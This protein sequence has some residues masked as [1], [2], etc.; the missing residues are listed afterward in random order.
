M[1]ANT[2]PSYKKVYDNVELVLDEQGNL[3]GV[4]ASDDLKNIAIFIS[5]T[6]KGLKRQA[7]AIKIAKRII[8]LVKHRMSEPTA[9]PSDMAKTIDDSIQAGLDANGFYLDKDH[10]PDLFVP[11]SQALEHAKKARD[12]ARQSTSTGFYNEAAAWAPYQL[13]LLIEILVRKYFAEQVKKAMSKRKAAQMINLTQEEKEQIKPWLQQHVTN[14][15]YSVPVNDDN[16]YLGNEDIPEED[17]QARDESHERVQAGW[18]SEANALYTKF[19]LL[20][21]SAHIVD[22]PASHSDDKRK[23]MWHIAAITTFDTDVKDMPEL[24]KHLV[25]VARSQSNKDDLKT[26]D[27]IKDDKQVSSKVLADTLIGLFDKDPDFYNKTE[28]EDSDVPTAIDTNNTFS[29][30][31]PDYEPE[32]E[33]DDK[34]DMSF[35]SDS[36][37]KDYE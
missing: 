9:R 17:V 20:K 30:D 33:S 14:I 36:F 2:Q 29:M 11:F 1:A 27:E 13:A 35:D 37:I 31:M 34:I 8:D 10:T 22:R 6:E 21:G 12:H 23:D 18:D 3:E 7:K 19:P 16:S 32:P 15:I 25:E 4:T 5:N 26:M 24:V 28:Q